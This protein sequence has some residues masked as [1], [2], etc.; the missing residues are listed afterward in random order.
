MQLKFCAQP[1]RDDSAYRG[2]GTGR[3]PSFATMSWRST[4]CRTMS[5]CHPF[6]VSVPVE[7]LPAKEEYFNGVRRWRCKAA[8]PFVYCQ[9]TRNKILGEEYWSVMSRYYIFSLLDFTTGFCTSKV[10]GF[11]LTETSSFSPE[12]RRNW[13]YSN[14]LP[15]PVRINHSTIQSENGRL[16]EI[17][18]MYCVKKFY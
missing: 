2:H 13:S 12:T 3:N 7:S 1:N 8:S 4:W 15:L 10:E 11:P 6:D 14:L 16:L 17:G 5:I 18:V 9:S